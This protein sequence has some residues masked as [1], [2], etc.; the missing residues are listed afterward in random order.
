MMTSRPPMPPPAAAAGERASAC[1]RRPPPPPRPRSDTRPVSSL[2]L[3]LK[4]TSRIP[5]PSL[6]ALVPATA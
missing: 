3:G 4:R 6:R 5:S 2:A 1:R